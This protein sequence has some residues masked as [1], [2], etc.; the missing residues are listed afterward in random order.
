M[1]ATLPT[2]D[3]D[4]SPLAA[5]VRDLRLQVDRLAARVL[6]LEARSAEPAPASGAPVDEPDLATGGTSWLQHSGALRRIATI[7]FV[8]V[9]ALVLRTL[10]DGGIV[11]KGLGV[12]LGV[13]YA[14]ALLA[15]GWRRFAADRPGKRVFTICGALLLCSLVLETHSRFEYL[16][17]TTAH[18]LLLAALA[19]SAFL[20]L[21]YTSPIV[22][23]L[24][25]LGAATTAIALGFPLPEFHITAATLVLAMVVATI[26]PRRAVAWLPWATA[27]LLLFFWFVW[28][29]KLHTVLARG[30]PIGAELRLPWFLPE[31]AATFAS[32]L[33]IAWVQARSRRGLL[34]LALPTGNVAF[35]C[36]AAG[37]VVVPWLAAGR[38]LGIAALALGG[39]H[40][41]LA[42][43][44]RTRGGNPAAPASFGVAAIVAFV[45]G[46]WLATGSLQVTLPATAALALAAAAWS[47]RI[48]SGG[49]RAVALGLQVGTTV[50]AIVGGLFAAPAAAPWLGIA[51]G[52]TLATLAGRH[53]R[54]TRSTPP[55]PASFYARWTPTDLPGHA[56]FWATI[57][58]VFGSLRVAVHPVL[59]ALPIDVDNAFAG[60]QSV[61]GNGIAIAL[62]VHA[63]RHQSRSTLRSAVVVA[64]IGGAKVFTSDF[65][66]LH[67][68]PLVL[69]VFSFGLAA[70]VGSY[71]LGRWPQTREGTA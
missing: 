71:V 16:P 8:L 40:A 34:M 25:V 45:P 18:G 63:W 48:D 32:L 62:L 59:A 51:L 58:C 21:R 35:T 69:S 31:L 10:T 70:A 28:A 55:P 61:L 42:Q 43:R 2:S 52:V 46:L 47:A 1:S 67:G 39:L 49:L 27:T 3:P 54:W 41:L 13:A 6:A 53:Y 24:G 33:A 17:A 57:A 4:R 14:G 38:W 44:A 60:A 22:I 30:E 15:V 5:E 37:A 64:A 7:T 68:V 29:F 9:V 26:A 11:D 56:L 36:A 66:T 23:D 65:L 50:T 20:G 19:V 12:W